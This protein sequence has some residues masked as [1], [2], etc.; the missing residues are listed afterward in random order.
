MALALSGGPE[1]PLRGLLP[2]SLPVNNEEIFSDA[3]E[4]KGNSLPAAR[5]EAPL[6]PSY[7]ADTR[8]AFLIPSC[9]LLIPGW[10]SRY[11]R[12]PF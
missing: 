1:L 9:L 11:P 6:L 12:T 4:A 5:L 10:S 3:G 8:L 7:S 2:L